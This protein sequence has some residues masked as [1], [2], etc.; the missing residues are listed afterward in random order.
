MA[1]S[2]K[3]VAKLHRS[4]QVLREL[5]IGGRVQTAE[6]D[7]SS[8]ETWRDKFKKRQLSTFLDSALTCN[9]PWTV[10]INGLAGTITAAKIAAKAIDGSPVALLTKAD[11]TPLTKGKT[12]T[13]SHTVDSFVLTGTPTLAA[14]DAIR[15]KLSGGNGLLSG[16]AVILEMTLS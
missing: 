2:D 3:Q 5:N 12:V 11:G 4:L 14:N 7:I 6:T 10:L 16:I 13:G 1:L 15:L 8:L 9:S